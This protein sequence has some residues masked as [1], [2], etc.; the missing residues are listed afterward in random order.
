MTFGV[1][2][3]NENNQE[4]F[5]VVPVTWEEQSGQV[6]Q[7]LDSGDFVKAEFDLCAYH[8][9]HPGLFRPNEGFERVSDCRA[10]VKIHPDASIRLIGKSILPE[11][12]AIPWKWCS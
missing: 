6:A 8:V 2:Q 10:D 4:D 5:L 7:I 9:F 3:L 12:R 11:N 1:L